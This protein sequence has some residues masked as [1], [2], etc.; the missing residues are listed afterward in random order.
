MIVRRLVTAAALVLLGLCLPATAFAQAS[1]T[2]VVRDAS[3]AVL[4]GVTVEA[5]S[6]ALIEKVRTGVTGG[7]GQYRIENLPPGTYT[8]SF[9]LTGFSV[10]SKTWM[11]QT[12][13]INADLYLPKDD[14]RHVQLIATSRMSTRQKRAGSPVID[15][16]DR[17][18]A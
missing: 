10:G 11:E 14:H 2:G 8:V 13:T 9:T 6:P 17:R 5:S 1:I 18:E 16:S 15:D 12:A 3:G 4:P 7:T